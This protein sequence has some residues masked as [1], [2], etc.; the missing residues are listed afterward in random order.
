M[1]EVNVRFLGSEWRHRMFDVCGVGWFRRREERDVF[2]T[3]LD[4]DHLPL[5][6]YVI[7]A[8]LRFFAAGDLLPAL[9]RRYGDSFEVAEYDDVLRLEHT[10][11]SKGRFVTRTTYAFFIRNAMVI[12]ECNSPNRLIREYSPRFAF[13]FVS[14]QSHRHPVGFNNRRRDVFILH[15]KV[16]KP[17]APNVI[18][19]I[20]FSYTEEDREFY[21]RYVA[22]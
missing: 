22:H 9:L 12:P 11:V 15:N 20:V 4:P 2:I 5:K 16:W 19:K 10:T 13:L 3:H 8:P 1:R 7:G 14:Y 17:Y 18:P 21:N 6:E